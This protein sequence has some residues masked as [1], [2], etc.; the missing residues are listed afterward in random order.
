MTGRMAAGVVAA[1][2]IATG[3]G[4]SA[5]QDH[6]HGAGDPEFGIVTV[7]IDHETPGANPLR[8]HYVRF[9]AATDTPASPIVYLA[10]GPGGAATTASNG[11]MGGYFV[12]LREFGDVIAFDQR[13]TGRSD[14]EDMMCEGDATLRLDNALDP[15][16]YR[17]WSREQYRACIA[18]MAARNISLHA[19]TTA[20]SVA[21][22]EAL[23]VR[24]DVP[25]LTLFGVDYGTQLALAYART[26]PSRVERMILAGV[27]GPD[28][29]FTLPSEADSA[30]MRLSTLTAGVLP[31][32]EPSL[33]DLIVS[34]IAALGQAPA[35]VDFLGETIEVGEW[36]LRRFVAR[37]FGN[38]AQMQRLPAALYAMSQG[39]FWELARWAYGFRTGNRT[40]PMTV[41]MTCASYG[42]TERLARIDRERS[43]TIL[44]PAIDA[45]LPDACDVPGLPRLPESFREPITSDVPVLFIGGT[46]DGRT[47]VS[48][49]RDVAKGF[50]FASTIVV[51]GAASVDDML[52]TSPEVLTGIQRFLSGQP[53]ESGRVEGPAWRFRRPYAKSLEREML[54][55]LMGDG[56]D[57]AVTRYWEIRAKYPYGDVYDFGESI[58]NVFG[59]DL[60]GLD[61]ID[62]AIDILRINTEAF[63]NRFNTW[64]SLAEA[65]MTKGDDKRA[66]AY[67]ERSLELNE[68][69]RNAVAILE[70]LRSES[71]VR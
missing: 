25:R 20:A 56:Y 15:A 10:G 65:Y 6:A 40:F 4:P 53:V 34:T 5:A 43:D 26:H 58:L 71:P 60:M 1:A 66:I 55:V 61:R 13:G 23:R 49:A 17:E 52:L 69:N 22:L 54:T 57:A 8:L 37:S 16:T 59:Y 36:D 31:P 48:N 50:A 21:D 35:R 30:L 44:G 51:D 68:N 2:A 70:R 18:D 39:E 47:P 11:R 24:L 62:L 19:F 12:A 41:A 28:H 42:S 45:P 38:R 27:Q 46:M 14:P 32:E 7:P 9:P 33:V 3:A 29:T 64:D 63:P 67:Y